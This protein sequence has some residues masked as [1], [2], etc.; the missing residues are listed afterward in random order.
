MG[1]GI[2]YSGMLFAHLH[3]ILLMIEKHPYNVVYYL[4]L[5]IEVIWLADKTELKVFNM[6][7]NSL[8]KIVYPNHLFRIVDSLVVDLAPPGTFSPGKFTE[9]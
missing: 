9:N 3:D 7:W 1:I 5:Y 2:G 4:V 6:S 8:S